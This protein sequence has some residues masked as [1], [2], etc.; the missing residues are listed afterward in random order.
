MVAKQKGSKTHQPSEIQS[1]VHQKK[2]TIN[3]MRHRAGRIPSERHFSTET[4]ASKTKWTELNRERFGNNKRN[5]RID[6][7]TQ[8]TIRLD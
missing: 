7:D 3:Q 5:L 1:P 4:K 6:D 2:K 8:R